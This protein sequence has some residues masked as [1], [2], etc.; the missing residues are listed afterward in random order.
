[1]VNEL[2]ANAFKYAFPGGHGRVVLGFARREGVVALTVADD[3]VGQAGATG[4]PSSSGK[5][6]RFVEAFVRE[7]G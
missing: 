1:M 2:A 5:G 3:G 7:V 4:G 6:S